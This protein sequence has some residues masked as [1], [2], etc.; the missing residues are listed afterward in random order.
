MK[1]KNLTA[2]N[3]IHRQTKKEDKYDGLFSKK[4]MQDL[5]GGI[6][7]IVIEKMSKSGLKELREKSRRQGVGMNM[8]S[9]Y[10]KEW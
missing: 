7:D 3:Y 9:P 2:N 6:D 8:H 1:G 10:D 4:Q 5:D